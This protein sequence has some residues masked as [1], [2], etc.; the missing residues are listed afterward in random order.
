MIVDGHEDIAWNILTFG[1]DYSM[2]LQAI[3]QSEQFTQ[4]P[5]QN[6]NTLLG[7]DVWRDGDIAVVFATLFV[8][9][10]R[11]KAGE[12]ETITYQTQRQANDHALRQLEVYQRLA[13]E[14]SFRMIET[15]S[16]LEQCLKARE[17]VESDDAEKPIGLVLLM[18][19]ADPI[20]E[21]EQVAEWYERGLRMIGPAW[22]STRY[23]GGTHEPGPLT[24]DGRRL[25]DRMQDLG[26]ILDLSHLSEEAYLQAID[27]YEGTVI[28]S[29]SNPRRFLPT[30]RGLSDQMIRLLVERDGV[31]G[32]IPYNKFLKATWKRG[33]P[34]DQVTIQDVA[35]VIDHICQLT[36]SADYVA[37]GSDFDGSF[38]LEHVPAEFDSVA[39]LNKL[40]AVLA[41]R[42]YTPEQIACVFADNWLRILRKGLPV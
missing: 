6:G 5:A 35:D 17:E 9:P 30:S 16:D 1:R 2:T 23:A 25:L 4:I 42:G 33:D 24:D 3:R 14:G 19:G 18:E 12:W 40:N 29:H 7:R 27:R 26:M 8:A 34:K 11:S 10:E 37:L 15:R 22:E 28:A 13:D 31:I 39:D 21:P 20:L 36:G 38:G 41:E 32:A